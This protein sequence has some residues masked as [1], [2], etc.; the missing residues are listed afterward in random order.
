M[1]AWL[2]LA[3]AVT[4]CGGPPP[5][6]PNPS[7]PLDERR[8]VDLI[9]EAFREE[10]DRPVPGAVVALTE[11]KRIHVDVTA[12]EHKYGVAYITALER[13]ELGTALPEKDPSMGDALQLVSG[14]GED[15]DARVLVLRDSDYLYDD[16]LGDEREPPTATVERRL[17][18][19]VHDFIVRA[20]AEKWP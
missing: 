12:G 2:A 9:I 4:A 10:K 5:R 20:H 14:L 19:D 6:A 16:Q 13:V 1:K 8:A 17:K 3:C 7:R 18:R 11:S 15:G